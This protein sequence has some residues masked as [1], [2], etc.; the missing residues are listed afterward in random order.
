MDER[1]T[2]REW[3]P[4]GEVALRI[5]RLLE[6]LMVVERCING[7][8]QP[9]V[10]DRMRQYTDSRTRSMREHGERNAKETE[11]HLW[12]RMEQMDQD[13]TRQRDEYKNYS[14]KQDARMGSLE[15]KLAQYTGALAVVVV[16]INVLMKVWK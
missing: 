14:E 15:R 11:G 3:M 7:N 9:G 6:R 10:E 8:G 16:A 13:L 2:E 4:K 12:K 1:P 5:D